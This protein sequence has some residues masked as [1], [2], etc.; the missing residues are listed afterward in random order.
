MYPP[1]QSDAISG[2]ATLGR[3]IAV[4]WR[5]AEV[6]DA[7]ALPAIVA[8]DARTMAPVVMYLNIF[9]LLTLPLF[10]FDIRSAEP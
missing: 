2:R 7:D 3:V 1:K 10:K 5:F 9:I 4:S 6:T 8:M